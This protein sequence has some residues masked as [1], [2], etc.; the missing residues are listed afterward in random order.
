MSNPR[1]LAAMA[2]L[3]VA[4]EGAYSNLL[5]NNTLKAAELSKEDKSLCTTIFYGTLDRLITVDY[6]LKQLI[7]TPLKKVKG[8]TLAVLRTAVFQIKFLDKIPDSAAVNEAVKLIKKSKESYNAAF[9]NGVLRNLLRSD[10]SL[11]N[12]NISVLYSCPEWIADILIRD[13][14]EKFAKE[15]LK[16]S[17]L[18]PPIYIRINT[19]KTSYEVLKSVFEEKNI[20][21]RK[22]E[23]DSIFVLSGANSVEKLE[24]YK[25][26]LFFVQDLSCQRAIDMLGIAST[27]RVLDICAAPGGKSFSAALYAGDGEVVSC[28]LYEHRTQLIKDGAERL[29]LNNIT[30]IC[31]DATRFNDKLGLFDT[32]ICDVPCSGLGVIRRK[33]DIK[34]NK[35]D[36]F[37]ELT[38]IQRKILHNA[39]NYLKVGGK[40]LYSTCTLN[41]LENRENVDAFL[42][43]HKGFV[44]EEDYTFSP[45][46][47]K[48]DGFYAAIISKKE[49]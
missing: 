47:D 14:G 40:L 32:V 37:E 33:P 30:A 45:Q 49:V 1:H 28:D 31:E 41:K 46:N 15:F 5:L 7:K 22:T 26:G 24:E 38:V 8:Y 42:N 2:L 4:E 11:P 35:E 44:L 18:P 23:Y 43:E 20:L 34:Y 19:L 10:I 16:D 6:Y 12:D 39:A 29:G 9:V 36:N 17:L 3:R 48:S 13:Y 21:L 25:K 27:A